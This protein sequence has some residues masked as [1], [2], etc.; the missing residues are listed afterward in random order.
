MTDEWTPSIYANGHSALTV[1]T[2]LH[3]ARRLYP[4]PVFGLRSA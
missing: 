1:S 2:P 3:F 4:R